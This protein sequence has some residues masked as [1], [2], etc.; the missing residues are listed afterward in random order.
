MILNNKKQCNTVKKKEK[1]IKNSF[2]VFWMLYSNKNMEENWLNCVKY[3]TMCPTKHFILNYAKYYFFFHSFDY[4]G[5]L[6]WAAFPKSI[7]SRS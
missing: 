1:V 4:W 3:G 5:K 2:F 7:T 6:T